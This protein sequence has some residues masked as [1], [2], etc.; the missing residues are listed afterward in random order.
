MAGITTSMSTSFKLDLLSAL[1]C[2][3]AP[4]VPTSAATHTNNT[5]DGISSLTGIAVGMIVTGNGCPTNCTVVAITGANALSV[6]PATTTS[7]STASQFTFTGDNYYFGLIKHTPT[8][9]YDTTTTNYTQVTGNSDEVGNSGTYAAGGILLTNVSAANGGTTAY[10]T[11]GANPSWTGATLDVDGGFLY[12]K[13][14]RGPIAT[15]MVG[16]FDFGGEQKVTA[17]TLTVILPAAA[18]TT[19]IV[20]IA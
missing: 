1:D 9:T 3:N 2:F 8:G 6:F 18:N 10:I 12:N 14:Q 19:A 15:R 17:C 7:N 20:R 4:I 5:I 13:T 16:V 11:F